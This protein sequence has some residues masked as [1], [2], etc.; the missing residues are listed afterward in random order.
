[1]HVKPTRI[2]LFMKENACKGCYCNRVARK[3]FYFCH[4]KLQKSHIRTMKKALTICMACLQVALFSACH[5][6][7]NHS[8]EEAHEEHTDTHDKHE[9][10]HGADEIIFSPEQAA[11]AGL[12]TEE[13]KPTDFN[14]VVEVSGRIMP[15]PGTEVTVTATMAGIVEF[16]VKD[17]TDGLQVGKGQ[18]LMRINASA[19][20]DGNPAA[21]AQA[22]LTT[23]RTALERAE[24]LAK[25]RIISQ[26]EL[27]D[28]RLR[29]ETAQSTARSLGNA[30]QQRHVT[31]PM[32]GYVKNVAV[33]AGDY[34]QAGQALATVTQR[35]RLQLRADLPERHYS[36]LSHITTANF[37]PA[38]EEG[39]RTYSLAE[40][41]GR[42]M[43]KGQAT[44]DTEHFV[45]ITFEFDN[46]G[47]IV[48][49]SFAQVFLQGE[50]QHGVLSVPVDAITEA[51]GLHFVYVQIHPDV[52]RRQE[53]KTG[54]SNGRRTEITAGLKAGDKVVTAGATQVRLAANATVIPEGHSH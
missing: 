11:A 19:M 43:A 16:A 41:N 33:K 5:A 48:P 50:T 17:L 2:L 42:V 27:E 38:Y 36:L 32:A 4:V 25:D 47:D 6:G 21:T 35:R 9:H 15:A 3:K 52:Y 34:V 46:K 40:M 8:E 53:V 24:R 12:Q 30:T 28:A 23:A 39:T 51:Q 45:P 10:E 37:R 14:E 22:E 26:R 54:A 29:Y 13:V 49:G 20:A 1:M 7:H 44:D 18:T 31:A